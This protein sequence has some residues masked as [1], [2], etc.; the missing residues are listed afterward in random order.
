MPTRILLTY[1]ILHKIG[2]KSQ[3]GILLLILQLLK[4]GILQK[5]ILL[6]SDERNS[7]CNL[8]HLICSHFMISGT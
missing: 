5:I 1:L 4:R 7:G 2:V 6:L 3:K 8:L